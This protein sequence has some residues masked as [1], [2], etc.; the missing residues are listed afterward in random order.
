MT[1]KEFWLRAAMWGSYVR[2]G[3]PGAVMYGFDERG[4][5]QSE[6]HRAACIAYL[7]THCRPIAKANDGGQDALKSP[8]EKEVNELIDYLKTAPEVTSY[9]R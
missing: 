5:V 7:D 3:D 2:N 9:R 8:Y 6:E 1:P 4:E